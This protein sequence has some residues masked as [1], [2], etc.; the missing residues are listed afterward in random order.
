[1][2]YLEAA[3]RVLFED[4]AHQELPYREITERAIKA[5]YLSPNGLTPAQTMYVQLMTDVKRRAARGDEPR[6]VQL[7]KG[8]F[9]LAAWVEGDLV[10]QI[11]RHNRE[12]KRELLLRLKA[13][14]PAEFEKLIGQ[15]LTAIGFE[16]VVV[17]KPADDGGV[18]VFGVL[19]TGGVVRTRMA[20]QVKRWKGNV[21]APTVQQVRGALGVHDQ[22]LIITTGSFSAGARHEASLPDRIP[23]ALMGGDELVGLLVEHEI[24]VTRSNPDLLELLK[25]DE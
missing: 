7:P 21:R 9:G 8:E 5:G 18:D 25:L 19:V 4:K 12:I 22:G 15:L 11:T 1:M 17:T 3:E 2:T 20:V 23:V 10:A 14:P 13:M 16:E 6:F 24:G